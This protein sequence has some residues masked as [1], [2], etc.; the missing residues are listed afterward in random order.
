MLVK[1]SYLEQQEE[2]KQINSSVSWDRG[3]P[4]KVSKTR[5]WHRATT[6]C[7]ALKRGEDE[8]PRRK[9][10][11][12]Q[13]SDAHTHNGKPISRLPSYVSVTYPCSSCTSPSGEE[14]SRDLSFGESFD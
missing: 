4:P 10:L 7:S 8:M 13:A 14:S 12:S 2:R 9:M 11:N 3:A 5:E 6:K 1:Q